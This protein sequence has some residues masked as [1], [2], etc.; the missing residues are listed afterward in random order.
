MRLACRLRVIRGERSLRELAAVSGINRG[1]LSRIERGRQ[2]PADKQ[3]GALEELYGAPAHE[4][5]AHPAAL[6]AIQTDD[7]GEPA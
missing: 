2:L 4:W 6:L 1:T 7:G 3:V 5:Y